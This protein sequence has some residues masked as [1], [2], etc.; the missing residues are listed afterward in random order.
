MVRLYLDENVDGAIAAGLRRRGVDVLTVQEDERSGTAD[1][2]VLRRSGELGRVLFSQ[3]TD[4]LVEAAECWRRGVAFCGVIYAHQRDVPAGICVRE[5]E[6]IPTLGEAEE[7]QNR[8]TF[9]PL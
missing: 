2:E 4:L 8:V 9:L 1:P 7:F 3:D 6:L 5:L